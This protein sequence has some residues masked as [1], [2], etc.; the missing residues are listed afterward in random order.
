MRQATPHGILLAGKAQPIGAAEKEGNDD[1]GGRRYGRG[2]WHDLARV[3]GGGQ[4]GA[5]TRAPG[6]PFFSAGPTGFGYLS[7][8]A[9]R[10]GSASGARG[11]ARSRL[12]GCRPGGRRYG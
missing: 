8:G 12:R 10:V 1:S 2:R 11:P 3:V 7:R 5:H 6:L 4:G 9:D